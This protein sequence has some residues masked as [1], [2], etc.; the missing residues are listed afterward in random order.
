MTKQEL[1]AAQ[2][3]VVKKAEAKLATTGEAEK[4]ALAA[5]KAAWT[6]LSKARE[7]LERLNLLPDDPI[8]QEEAEASGINPELGK[9]YLETVTLSIGAYDRLKTIEMRAQAQLKKITILAEGYVLDPQKKI[10]GDLLIETFSEILYGS[11]ADSS[12]SS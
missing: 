12:K 7:K 6:E 4:T 5:W 3:A 9:G 8:V 1:I 11:F 10:I 2:E